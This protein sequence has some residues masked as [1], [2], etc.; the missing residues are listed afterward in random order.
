MKG[1]D[2]CVARNMKDLSLHIL[3]IFQNSVRAGATLVTLRVTCSQYANRVMFEVEDNGC[4]MDEKTILQV[5]DPFYTSR[6]MRKVGLGISLLLQN[7]LQSGGNVDIKSQIG[8]GTSLKA[9]F[10]FNHWDRPPMGDLGDMVSLLIS[11]N[12]SIKLIFEAKSDEGE[13]TIDSSMIEEVLDGL[14]VGLPQVVIFIKE[15]IQEN[16]E[17][18][19]IENK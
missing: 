13:Y 3:D 14:E 15:M 7:A 11:G 9:W 2:G 10:E 6:T 17:A 18:I 5:S 8:V 12:P 16:L 1:V 19:G 4:G